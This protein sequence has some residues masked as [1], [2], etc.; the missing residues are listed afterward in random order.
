M[1]NGYEVTIFTSYASPVL[2]VKRKDGNEE[3]TFGPDFDR[4]ATTKRRLNQ[5]IEEEFPEIYELI[6]YNKRTFSERVFAARDYGL[7]KVSRIRV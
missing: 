3:I 6:H 4:S 1:E 2:E 5:F 7:V